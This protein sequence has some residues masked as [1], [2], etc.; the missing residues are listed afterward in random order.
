[1][2]SNNPLQT[3]SGGQAS[4]ISAKSVTNNC[5]SSSS[6]PAYLSSAVQNATPSI[7]EITYSQSLT[8]I[9]P[10]NSAFNVQINSIA[11]SINTVTVSGT[12]VQLTIAGAIKFG[13][14]VTVTYTKPA[15]NPLQSATGA[16]A[17][18]ISGKLITNNILSVTKDVTP[19][20]ITMTISPNRVHRIINVLLQ[21][22]SS[23]S[24]LDPAVSPQIIRI[25]DNYGK[26]YLEKLLVTGV[27]SI[28][29]P[30]NLRYGIYN[31]LMF[32]GALQTSAQKI[33]VY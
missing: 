21:Y 29:I 23:F 30:I 14:I 31:V 19:L 27:T 1:M 16:E 10:P 22:P 25:F 20:K 2:P 33:S 6:V 11:T 13:D 18:S 3:A 32:S 9:V 7:I 17:T 12:K 4:S 26:L 5:S 15:I 24:I 28:K 8:N